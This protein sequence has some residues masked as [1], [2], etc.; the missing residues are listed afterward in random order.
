[1][2]TIINVTAASIIIGLVVCAACL[3]AG[4]FGYRA[5]KAATIKEYM[6]DDMAEEF[7]YKG[8]IAGE[9]AARKC[10]SHSHNHNHREEHKDAQ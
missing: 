6:P 2:D 3:I 7:Y 9:K 8:F 1:M 5:G 10:L 4:W